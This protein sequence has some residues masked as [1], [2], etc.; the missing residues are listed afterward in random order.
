MMEATERRMYLELGLLDEDLTRE[1]LIH[2]AKGTPPFNGTG[3]G[4][5]NLGADCEL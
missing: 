3:H 5:K 1:G 4:H 2:A